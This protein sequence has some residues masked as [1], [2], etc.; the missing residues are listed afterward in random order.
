MDGWMRG[1]PGL[2]LWQHST[3][4]ILVLKQLHLLT[5]HQQTSYREC[6]R[7]I[8]TQIDIVGRRNTD[9]QARASAVAQAEDRIRDA[10]QH[11]RAMES[12]LSG[13]EVC[14]CVGGGWV[15]VCA[16][17]RACVPRALAYMRIDPASSSLPYA[18]YRLRA[19]AHARTYMRARARTHYTS[20]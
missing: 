13:L 16:C 5:P 18:R 14:V 6:A 17:V 20:A 8:N 9:G 4:A 3:R 11:L 10:T 1:H 15:S 7:A 12:A 2:Q 19:R